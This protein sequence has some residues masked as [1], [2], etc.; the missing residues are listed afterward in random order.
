M[1]MQVR[2]GA[3]DSLTSNTE[4]GQ[5]VQEACDELGVLGSLVSLAQLQNHLPVPLQIAGILHQCQRCQ[6]LCRTF[7]TTAFTEHSSLRSE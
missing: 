7:S 4:L 1:L 5:A 3:N 6:L 2:G